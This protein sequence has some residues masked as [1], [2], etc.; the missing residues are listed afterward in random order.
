V[1]HKIV[2]ARKILVPMEQVGVKWCKLNLAGP[3][4]FREMKHFYHAPIVLLCNDKVNAHMYFGRYGVKFP[5]RAD[6]LV[7]VAFAADIIMYKCFRSVKRKGDRGNPGIPQPFH[8]ILVQQQSIGTQVNGYAFI[9]GVVN[10]FE[11]IFA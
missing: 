1:E 6:G 2:T 5:N 10:N 3:E 7:E 8:F 9:L 4:G 11:N